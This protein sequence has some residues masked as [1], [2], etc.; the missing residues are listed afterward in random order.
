MKKKTYRA[1]GFALLGVFLLAIFNSFYIIDLL[2]KYD[3]Y[4]VI[5]GLITMGSFFSGIIF[6]IKGYK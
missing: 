5:M 1:L 6:M 2:L 3:S 4:K